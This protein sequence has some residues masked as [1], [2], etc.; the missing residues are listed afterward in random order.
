MTDAFFAPVRDVMTTAPKCIDGMATLSD[1]LAIMRA[2]N[3]SSLIVNR[4]DE[5]DEYG[6]ILIVNIAAKIINEKRPTA[7]ISVY[8]IMTKPAPA[9]DADMNIK[10]AIRHM[11][12]LGLSHCVVAKGRDLIGI[13]TLRDM[14]LRYI[15]L[16]EIGRQ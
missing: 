6:I 7:R 11:V 13:V 5:R 12:S 15:E 10:Y 3:I 1:A 4:R 2:E 14:T 8:E 16:S 9:I